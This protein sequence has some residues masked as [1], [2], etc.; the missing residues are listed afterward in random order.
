MKDDIDRVTTA[1]RS[2]LPRLDTTPTEV[3]GRVARLA[4]HLELA[5]RETLAARDL[6][7]WEIDVLEAL[8]SAGKPFQL[9][10][11][12]L[13]QATL[14]ASGTMTNRVDRLA[15]RG[16]VSREPDPS[17]GRGILVRLTASGRRKTDSAL[18]ALA[19]AEAELLANLSERRRAALVTGLRE[20]LAPLDS[21]DQES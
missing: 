11:G 20:L 15:R 4:R 21:G 12:A 1:L 18:T 6:E 5:R 3:F 17:D 19:A 2:E 7:P 16:F 10:P 9:S 13:M 8:R 14:V